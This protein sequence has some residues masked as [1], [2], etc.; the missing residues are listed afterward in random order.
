[1]MVTSWTEPLDEFDEWLTTNE[2]WLDSSSLDSYPEL[3]TS[4]GIDEALTSKAME[5][6]EALSGE[7]YESLL[8]REENTGRKQYISSVVGDDEVNTS[9][10]LLY[11]VMIAIAGIEI[12]NIKVSWKDT[13]ISRTVANF[14]EGW[15][16]SPPSSEASFEACSRRH[17][18]NGVAWVLDVPKLKY[19][20]PVRK[21][22]QFELDL[23]SKYI[24]LSK[25]ARWT[26]RKWFT[27]DFHQMALILANCIFDFVGGRTFPFLYPEEGGCGGAPPYG[28]L[29][30]AASHLYRFNRGRSSNAVLGVMDETV[31]IHHGQLAPK[32]GLFVKASH[33]AQMGDKKWQNFTFA[34]KSVLKTGSYSRA[35]LRDLLRGEVQSNLPPDI[36]DFATEVLP[37]DPVMGSAISQL[38]REGFLLTELDV[39]LI[40][41]NRRRQDAI[42]GVTP[43]R[44]VIKDIE[45]QA[46]QFKANHWKVLTE[47]SKGIKANGL[48]TIAPLNWSEDLS[49]RAAPLWNILGS[50]YDLRSSQTE[51]F[52]SFQY[53]DTIRVFKRSDIER[54]IRKTPSLLRKDI[55][56]MID[57]PG[58]VRNF[59]TGIPQDKDRKKAIF[60]WLEGDDL[61]TLLL[62]PL[63]AGVGPDDARIYRS[64]SIRVNDPNIRSFNTIIGILVSSD[65]ALCR[66]LGTYFRHEFKDRVVIFLSI[67]SRTYASLCVKM[68]HE[69]ISR[70]DN[71][72]LVKNRLGKPPDLSI[73]NY[74]VGEE[75]PVPQEFE[76]QIM[77]YARGRDSRVLIE[78][79]YPNVERYLERTRFEKSSNTLLELQGGFLDR[80]TLNSLPDTFCW[81]ALPLSKIM[82]W[83]DFDKSEQKRYPARRIGSGAVMSYRPQYDGGTFSI[84]NWRR[85]VSQFDSA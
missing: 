29:E 60:D 44:D 21:Q 2:H 20:S 4:S 83:P 10:S 17:R 28:N 42:G 84:E 14:A 41:E 70:K 67:G 25:V 9:N 51:Q 79:D 31:R 26:H 1:M 81:S 77:S 73:F 52:T 54:Y 68:L 18:G 36:L 72:N 48:Y 58:I 38:R 19:I 85:S 47:L 27:Y 63:P 23:E 8:K 37:T 57:L 78:F 12:S 11:S 5:V 55:A 71:G 82:D 6:S 50:Y 46:R 7:S 15:I 80:R 74:L 16:L 22:S 24:H 59:E 34:Y 69:E 3:Y 30:T 53:S 76:E 66:R 56:Q 35:E 40:L 61:S 65:R 33:L 13:G 32:D 64:F 49:N 62:K 45:E 39:K 75:T 43:L